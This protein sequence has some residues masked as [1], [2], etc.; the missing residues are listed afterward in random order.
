V[1]TTAATYEDEQGDLE[2]K[3]AALRTTRETAEA[4]HRDALERLA[5]E[6]EA[7]QARTDA[8]LARLREE[9]EAEQ[10]AQTVL[11][12][13][14]RMQV[15]DAQAALV[16]IGRDEDAARQA[17]AAHAGLLAEVQ[18]LRTER[19]ELVARLTR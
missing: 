1:L 16:Q 7:A 13:A 10:A 5:T 2:R 6:R 17:A 15:A 19:D 4:E 18:A 14:L 9:G 8:V 12:E 11:L 3:L